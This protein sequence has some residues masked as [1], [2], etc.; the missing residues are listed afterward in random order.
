MFLLHN[1]AS[2]AG[3]F[4]GPPPLAQE[5]GTSPY[6]QEAFVHS[7]PD[8][9]EQTDL[10]DPSK[11]R[12]RE[13]DEHEHSNA[14][15]GGAELPDGGD[16]VQM[17]DASANADAAAAGAGASAAPAAGSP[18]A[19]VTSSTGPSA[20]AKREKPN[21]Q[22]PAREL[23]ELLTSS[24]AALGPRDR[25]ASKASRHAAITAVKQ[26]KEAERMELSEKEREARE[27]HLRLKREKE[28]A[29]KEK[30]REEQARKKEV[31]LNHARAMAIAQGREIDAAQLEAEVM[32]QLNGQA[33]GGKKVPKKAA[34]KGKGKSATPAG[35]PQASASG[36]PPVTAKAKSKKPAANTNGSNI[37]GTSG[38]KSKVR[39][40]CLSAILNHS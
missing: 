24:S 39:C 21:F 15:T 2:P 23:R 31:A 17:L 1:M 10:A 36:V 26:A 29:R 25:N 28:R 27:E 7:L 16:L 11:K 33:A 4:A 18:T 34:A 19:S 5:D 12:K 6:L 8:P 14:A 38:G 32:D 9:A 37:A 22:V 13:D 30:Q 40:V 20:G 3:P 35:A